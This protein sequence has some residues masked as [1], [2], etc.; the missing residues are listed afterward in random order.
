MLRSDPLV[1]ERIEKLIRAHNRELLIAGLT[2]LALGLL[3]TFFIYGICYWL[4]WVIQCFTTGWAWFDSYRPLIL[5]GILLT[6]AFYASYRRVN[7]L[8]GVVQL[9]E[10]EELALLAGEAVGIGTFV[11]PT[12]VFAGSLVVLFGGPASILQGISALLHRIRFDAKLLQTAS[13]VLARCEAGCPFKALLSPRAALLLKF[14]ALIKV[15]PLAEEDGCVLTEKG[16]KVLGRAKL[17]KKK[18][19]KESE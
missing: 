17:P 16:E 11:N 2:K 1:E 19:K 10:A 4:F 18:K 8:E 12:L 6:I 13:I 14:L 15:V 5:T 9:S 3:F 7:P